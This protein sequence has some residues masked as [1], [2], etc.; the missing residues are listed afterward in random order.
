M[1]VRLLLSKL[2]TSGMMVTVSPKLML[3]GSSKETK[4]GLLTTSSLLGEIPSPVSRERANASATQLVMVSGTIESILTTPLRLQWEEGDFLASMLPLPEQ[5]HISSHI[6]K[7]NHN[8]FFH[9]QHLFLSSCIHQLLRIQHNMIITL[10]P[11][12][13]TCT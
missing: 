4:N 8:V 11:H 1:I 3:K 6:C 13:L 10:G 7:S 5:C 2:N 12:L 9:I